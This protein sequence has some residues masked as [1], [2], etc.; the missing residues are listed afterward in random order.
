MLC[1]EIDLYNQGPF[2]DSLTQQGEPL[3]PRGM[4]EASGQLAVPQPLRYSG[5]IAWLRP[6]YVTAMDRRVG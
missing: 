2:A 1:L 4:T 6:F 3:P 5:E